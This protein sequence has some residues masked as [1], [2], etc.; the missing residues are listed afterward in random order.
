MPAPVH[1]LS[2]LPLWLSA[3]AATALAL[4]VAALLPWASL[5]AGDYQPS[6]I[7]PFH[8]AREAMWK[9]P[10]GDGW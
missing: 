7:G 2:S 3:L 4:S 5:Y 1:T 8:W 10:M 6:P 9:G